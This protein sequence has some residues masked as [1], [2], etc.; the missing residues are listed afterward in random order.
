MS[1]VLKFRI[2]DHELCI[3]EYGPHRRREWETRLFRAAN[4]LLYSD[5]GGGVLLFAVQPPGPTDSVRSGGCSFFCMG[6]LENDLLKRIL[7]L[8]WM[9]VKKG[10]SHAAGNH[11]WL[12]RQPIGEREALR[13]AAAVVGSS[14]P[15]LRKSQRPWREFRNCLVRRLLVG[16]VPGQGVVVE[17]VKGGK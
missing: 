14:A 12:P 11:T 15:S 10:R 7:T 17:G 13:H 8:I 4:N 3:C 6:C 2:I 1:S 5:G 9:A 16:G